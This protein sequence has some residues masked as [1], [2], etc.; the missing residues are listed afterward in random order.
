MPAS[1][2][3]IHNGQRLVNVSPSSLRAGRHDVA[4]AALVLLHVE[5]QRAF[6]R[7]QLL[8]LLHVDLAHVLD[9][10]GPP[11]QLYICSRV[12]EQHIHAASWQ[13]RMVTRSSWVCSSC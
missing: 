6:V 4:V 10:D 7:G 1:T 11:L 13:Q 5:A 8:D 3:D 12:C 9:V 2:F